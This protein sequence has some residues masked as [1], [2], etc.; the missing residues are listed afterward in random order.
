MCAHLRVS[1]VACVARK[2]RPCPSYS[3]RRNRINLGLWRSLYRGGGGV[4]EQPTAPIQQIADLD[5]VLPVETV[6][7][8]TNRQWRSC[9]S[10]DVR[11]ALAGES[12]VTAHVGG[13]GGATPRL[14]KSL[15]FSQTVAQGS[16]AWA[17]HA[18][19][20]QRRRKDNSVDGGLLPLPPI[21][22]FYPTIPPSK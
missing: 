7:Q 16:R 15:A 4:R 19:W 9:D 5:G 11:G 12:V 14:P 22:L 3:R 1:V 2:L 6:M 20:P 21:S 8:A 13:W 17:W 18:S 10:Q